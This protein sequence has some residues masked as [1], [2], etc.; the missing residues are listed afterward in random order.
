MSTESQLREKLR[1]ASPGMQ[2][3]G[4]REGPQDRAGGTAEPSNEAW[5]QVRT[6]VRFAHDRLALGK[7][8]VQ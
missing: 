6:S 3:E 1:M 8:D 7:R 2:L 4:D 5:Q